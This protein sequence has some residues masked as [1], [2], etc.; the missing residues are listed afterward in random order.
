MF[1]RD[2]FSPGYKSILCAFDRL[3]QQAS[4][5]SPRPRSEIR[6]A[7]TTKSPVASAVELK[8]PV[9][10]KLSNGISRQAPIASP[11]LSQSFDQPTMA[12]GKRN[13]AGPVVNASTPAEA[14]QCSVM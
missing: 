11:N 13:I 10:S 7:T 9:E 6:S 12:A 4:D 14:G 2:H 3:I 5:A 8:T 1:N